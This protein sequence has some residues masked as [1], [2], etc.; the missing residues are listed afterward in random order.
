MLREA[1]L[2]GPARPRA[3][4]PAATPRHHG[5]LS[6]RRNVLCHGNFP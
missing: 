4:A 5:M 1:F 6:A 2:R 3:I